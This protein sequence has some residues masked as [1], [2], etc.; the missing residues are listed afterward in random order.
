MND[1]AISFPE[2]WYR[3]RRVESA[4]NRFAP[5]SGE[6]FSIESQTMENALSLV[7]SSVENKLLNWLY[8]RDVLQMPSITGMVWG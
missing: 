4:G 6:I 2:N 8:V 5:V 7:T 3:W 1:A